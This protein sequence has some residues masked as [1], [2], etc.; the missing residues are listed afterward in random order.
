[1]YA[2]RSY[3]GQT[4]KAGFSRIESR[5]PKF[6]PKEIYGILPE[7]PIKPYNMY[8]LIARIV[9]DSKLD[10]YKAGY[11]RTVISYNFV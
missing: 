7:D 5:P 9:D 3:Y 6:S 10:E 11:G 4:L 8:E 1:M 2:I